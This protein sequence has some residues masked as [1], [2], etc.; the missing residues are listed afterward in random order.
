M[1]LKKMGVLQVTENWQEATHIVHSDPFHAD[2]VFSTALFLISG[3]NVA[4]C[5]VSSVPENISSNV[6]VYDIGLGEFDHHQVGG[7]GKRNYGTRTPYASCGLIWKK[8]HKKILDNFQCPANL[9]GLVFQEVDSMLIEGIDGRDNGIKQFKGISNYRAMN[10][11]Q[12]IGMYNVLWDDV[13]IDRNRAFVDA[14]EI[15]SQILIK[16]I[17]CAISKG[18]AKREIKNAIRKSENKILI[19]DRHMPWEETVIKNMSEKSKSLLYVVFPS[20]RGGY[21]VQGIPSA[22]GR[23]EQRKPFPKDWWGKSAEELKIITGVDDI[24]FCHNT[25]FLVSVSSLEGAL[26]VAK[27]AVDI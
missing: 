13:G 1:S 4:L 16:T 17:N 21:V 2:D 5:R 22:I 20:S 8:H 24:T 26:K 11:S 14:V 3:E 6:I 9:I 10:V 12:V 27:I 7:N 25:G 18:R 23:F 19:L 15:A